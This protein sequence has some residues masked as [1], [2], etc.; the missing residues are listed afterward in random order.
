[1]RV[2]YTS[3]AEYMV[4]V[5]KIQQ[6]KIKHNK[7]G[8]FA[9]SVGLSLFMDGSDRCKLLPTPPSTGLSTIQH[10]NSVN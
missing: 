9:G 1:M 10:L 7:T 4:D 2:C 3:K 6:N 5:K 8:N